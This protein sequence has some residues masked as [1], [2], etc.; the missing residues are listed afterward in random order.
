MQ[1]LPSVVEL[2]VG[3]ALF[4]TRLST[5]TKYENSMLAVMFS[6][7]H[8]LD[9]DKDGRYFIDRN[10]KHFSYVLDYLRN[11]TLP[12][13][14]VALKVYDEAKY[15][16][17]DILM[18]RLETYGLVHEK[19]L[20]E[21]LQSQIPNYHEKL[22]EIIHIAKRESLQVSQTKQSTDVWIGVRYN[23]DGLLHNEFKA[24]DH[25]C[26]FQPREG[27]SPDIRQENT[28]SFVF[29]GHMDTIRHVATHNLP[30]V[31]TN[32]LTKLKFNVSIIDNCTQ[33]TCVDCN[34]QYYEWQT[35]QKERYFSSY[36]AHWI[37]CGVGVLKYQLK[38]TWFENAP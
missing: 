10:G 35:G 11:D 9:K 20:L 21:K 36:Q 19:I 8:K 15:Y 2:N 22:A 17:L 6:G 7:R 26:K 3:G 37:H 32:D 30:L 27:D 12:P 5:L 18:E 28:V 24:T 16:G 29:T 38:F 23:Y 1:T 34:N 14:D 33:D 4:V 25:T 31:L 13:V